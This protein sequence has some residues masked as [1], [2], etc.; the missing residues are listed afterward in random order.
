M[1]IFDKRPNLVIGQGRW[2]GCVVWRPTTRG[3]CRLSHSVRVD[4]ALGRQH[5]DRPTPGNRYGCARWVRLVLW[6]PL[7][8]AIALQTGSDRCRDC[9]RNGR[10][11]TPV[12]KLTGANFCYD[13][14]RTQP[15]PSHESDESRHPTSLL[16][17]GRLATGRCHLPTKMTNP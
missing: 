7:G 6:F 17:Q 16:S 8:N 2:T 13:V 4:R 11:S 12:A 15:G 3:R 14:S 1:E 5:M 9:C 10:G